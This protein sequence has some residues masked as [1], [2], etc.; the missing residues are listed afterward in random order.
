MSDSLG[1]KISED[2]V[3]PDTALRQ[4]AKRTRRTA[5]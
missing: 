1:L 4:I 3:T 5:T 2:E